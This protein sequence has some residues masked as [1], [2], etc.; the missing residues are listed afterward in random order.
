MFVRVLVIG[1]ATA[2]CRPTEFA[3]DDKSDCAT[4]QLSG[5]CETNGW[6]SYR[7][8]A[9]TSGRRYGTQAGDGLAAACVPVMDGTSSGGTSSSG[10]G[11]SSP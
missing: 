2:S 5:Q 7:D 8:P 6:C 10:D 3:C 9:C 11:S 1:I 4:G